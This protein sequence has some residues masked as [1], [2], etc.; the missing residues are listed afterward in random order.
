MEEGVKHLILYHNRPSYYT[1]LSSFNT[2]SIAT[3]FNAIFI[4]FT[5]FIFIYCYLEKLIN[6]YPIRK[7]KQ[8]IDLAKGEVMAE[9]HCDS[10][11]V[12]SYNH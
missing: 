3:T 7:R 2:I 5:V 9:M 12:F 6:I 4:V 11:N 1:I 10:T 8:G